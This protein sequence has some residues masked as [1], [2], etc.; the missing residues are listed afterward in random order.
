MKKIIFI[1]SCYL[2]SFVS[3]SQTEELFQMRKPET[4]QLKV[5]QIYTSDTRIKINDIGLISSLSISGKIKLIDHK[6]LVRVILI[7]K[8]NKYLVFEGYTLIFDKIKILFNKHCDETSLLEDETPIELIIIVR[9]AEFELKS[10]HFSEENL[11][12]EE[13]SYLAKDKLEIKKS[14]EKYKVLKVNENNSKKNKTWL[15]GSTDISLLPF[16]KKKNFFG[17]D[18]GFITGGFEY[19]IEGIFS[20]ETFNPH[21]S[22]NLKSSLT[23]TYP[24]SFDWRNRHGEN[25]TTP[26]SLQLGCG[27]CTAFTAV[28]IT[29]MMTNLYFNDHLNLD[30]SEQEVWVCNSNGGSC[31]FGSDTYS[32]LTYIRDNGVSEENCFP[33]VEEDIS[34]LSCSSKCTNPDEIIS[35]NSILSIGNTINDFKN[36]L[37]FHGPYAGGVYY[38]GSSMSWHHAMAVVGYKVIETGDNIMQVGPNGGWGYFTVQPGSPLIGETYFIYKNSY[39]NNNGFHYIFFENGTSYMITTGGIQTPITS[40]NYNESD[41]K[42]VDKDNDGYFNWGIGTKPTT[43][44]Y[45]SPNSPDGDDSNPNLGPVDTYGNCTPISSPYAF[46]EHQ[47]TSSETWNNTTTE[48]GNVIVKNSGNLTINGATVNLEGDATFSVELGGILIINSG[49]IQ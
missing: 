44:P 1:I 30:L 18:Y 8:K 15:A 22:S 3:Y 49:T 19:Y 17:G 38:S 14:T 39:S 33:Y 23:S 28:A 37:I 47:I 10:I 41:R 29:E 20:F 43:C 4:K 11:S 25:W 7:T 2:L 35:F 9:N 36:Q 27:S 46:P 34:T 42:C 5:E 48:C 21:G 40:L 12:T 26:I 13:K 24:S 45:C 31:S 6:S 32:K 16:E